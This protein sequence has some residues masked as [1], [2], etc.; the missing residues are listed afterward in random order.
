M[1]Q[2]LR[3]GDLIV[4]AGRPSMGKTSL[5]LQF[6]RNVAGQNLPVCFFGLKG[7]P[8]GVIDI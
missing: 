1:T 4:F 7:E 5:A 6:A 3:R 2:G 8:S